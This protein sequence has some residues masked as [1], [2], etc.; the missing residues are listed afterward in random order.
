MNAIVI[1]Q[2]NGGNAPYFFYSPCSLNWTSMILELDIPTAI[3]HCSAQCLNVRNAANTWKNSWLQIIL[4]FHPAIPYPHRFGLK[5]C[6]MLRLDG[7]CA[8]V[9]AS[10]NV[11]RAS[12]AAT[13][14]D[15]LKWVKQDKRRMLHVVYRVGDLDRTI[16]YIYIS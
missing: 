5:A 11:S 7:N 14:E 10:G 15:V 9:M 12:P 8:R 4:G 16:K 3:I 6:K 2:Q 13:P 1:S